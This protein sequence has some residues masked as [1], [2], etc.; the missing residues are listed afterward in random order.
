VDDHAVAFLVRDTSPK[1]SARNERLAWQAK[2]ISSARNERLAWQAKP[3]SSARN[4][5]L[6]WQAKP[7]S[8]SAGQDMNLDAV[9]RELLG[10]LAHVAREA[11]LD[12]RRVLPAQDQH[13]R[14][15]HGAAGHYR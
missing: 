6:A 1:A 14:R 2:P 3:I 9:A 8:I 10:Q 7:I 5:R 4:E 13:A 15:T 11:A 12:D